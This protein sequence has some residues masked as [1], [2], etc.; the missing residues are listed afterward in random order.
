[1][2]GLLTN[3]TSVLEGFEACPHNRPSGEGVS[4]SEKILWTGTRVSLRGDSSREVKVRYFARKLCHFN[5]KLERP[6][7]K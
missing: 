7:S 4:D 1:M 2:D 5:T 6:V 3:T